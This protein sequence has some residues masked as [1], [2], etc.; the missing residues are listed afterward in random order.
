MLFPTAVLL[1]ELATLG[2]PVA[3]PHASLLGDDDAVVA[4][5]VQ[6]AIVADS[7]VV[8]PLAAGVPDGD[9]QDPQ[10]PEDKKP[11]GSEEKKPETPPHTGFHALFFGLIEDVRALPSRP[12]LYIAAGGGALAL[13]AHPADATLNEKLIS[14]G[15]LSHD[16]WYPGH[17][18]GSDPL[19]TVVAVGT[20]AYGRLFDEPKASHFGMDLLRAQIIAEGLTFGLKYAVGR[21]RP[22]HQGDPSFPSGHSAVTFATATV[23]ERHLGWKMAGLGYAIAAYVATSRLHDNVHYLSD[24]I[25]GAA[26]GTISGRTVTRHGRNY[27]TFSPV[28]MPGGGVAL[29]VTRDTTPR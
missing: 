28:P 16:L 6:P 11:G 14:H 8:L 18:V 15:T 1:V 7:G 12:N 21:E 29:M 13:A 10:G 5:N 26:V 27:W 2:T 22:N 4:V 3:A 24:V 23:I 20:F 17:I 9:A 25:F 19:Q